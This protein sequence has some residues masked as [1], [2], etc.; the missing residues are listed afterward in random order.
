MEDEL[1]VLLLEDVAKDVELIV[2]EVR[3]AAISCVIRT[4][5]CRSDFEKALDV[6]APDV[7][8][9]DYSLPGFDG[10]S[11]LAIARQ[12]RTDMP[13]ILISGALGE[14]AA[15]ESLKQGAT[16]YVLKTNLVRLAPAVRATIQHLTMRKEAERK[17]GASED[18]FRLIME[19]AKDLI[20]LL[21]TEG[22]RIY[23][24]NSYRSL[25][26]DVALLVGTDSFQEIHPEDRERVRRIFR[27]TVASG[28]GQRA[29]FRFLLGDGSVRHIESEGSVILDA[30]GQTAN[31]VVVSRDIT[32]SRWAEE[33]LR[34]AASALENTVES[35][36]I[37]DTSRRIVSVN[38]AF[39][40][41]T[42]FTAEEVLGKT[43]DVLRPQ[44]YDPDFYAEIWNTVQ[45]SG[46]WRGEIWNRRK[47]GDI[48]PELVSI[49]TVRN[50]AG[51]VTHHVSVATDITKFKHDQAQLEF[52]AHRDPLTALP[53]RTCF[54]DQCEETLLRTRRRRG[55][56]GLLYLDLDNFKTV[57]DSLGHAVGDQLL[58]AVAERLRGCMRKG[59]MLA[60]QGGDE[61]TVLLDELGQPE[62][63]TIVAGKLLNALAQP[64]LLSGHEL[65][66]SASIGISSYPQ[67]G[68]DVDT[69]LKNADAAMYR[70]KEQGRNTYQVFS[71]EINA[72]ALET[73]VMTNGL[74][75]ALE[76]QEFVLHYQP[77]VELD[78]G[79][80]AGVEALVRWQHSE[81]GLVSP[82]RFIP[83][84]EKTGLIIPIGEWVLKNA[85]AQAKAW[86]ERGLRPL[87]MAVNL[88]AS[89][90]RQPNLVERITAILAETGLDARWL[91][92][93]LTE[94]A[95]MQDP[96]RVIRVLSELRE[97][98][99]TIALDDFGTGYS[100]LNYLTRFPIDYL[101][102][103]QS[104]VQG[105]SEDSSNRAI[106]IA[107][108]A[109]AK[110]LALTVIAE[111]VERDEQLA[112]LRDHGCEEGQGYL[113]SKPLPAADLELALERIKD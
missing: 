103:D 86:Q 106:I 69:L 50:E 72:E 45:E 107:I 96:D 76:R 1:K 24:S 59:D 30:L 68:S 7:V 58:Q 98:G 93:E 19:N 64:F 90:F 3:K 100:S 23:S 33:Q 17:L 48:Y 5:E 36:I 73:L 49:S 77:V 39:V 20:A 78:S 67:D 46:C 53:N 85:C 71:A 8:L 16:D 63:A 94:S 34:L 11:A 27:D 65:F 80:I 75:S 82:A 70:A 51:N 104:F 101:K 44:N 111:G 41:V 87:R 92:I 91:E 81:Y 21:D 79:T 4:V 35:V 110:S 6:F 113:F 32:N 60:R 89:Q 112:F 12:K 99:I 10:L 43:P 97:M 62:D 74:R 28:V 88:S 66:V 40:I 105:V 54:H 14:E 2:R 38:K 57:N 37:V 26:G 22:K 108:I 109:M 95:V 56:I 47:N 84:A 52:L 18:K 61:F 15:I 55:L 31:V 13:F 29:Q 9:S 42:G 102:V 25:L 83:L